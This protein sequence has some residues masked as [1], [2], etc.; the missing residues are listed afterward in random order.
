MEQ[1][2]NNRTKNTRRIVLRTMAW[3]HWTENWSSLSITRNSAYFNLKLFFPNVDQFPIKY[4]TGPHHDEFRWE[5]PDILIS[6]GC[7]VVNQKG[8]LEYEMKNL[9]LSKLN[10]AG[11]ILEEKDRLWCLLFCKA[12]GDISSWVSYPLEGSNYESASRKSRHKETV[13]YWR[14]RFQRGWAWWKKKKKNN[15]IYLKSRPTVEF[16]L[17]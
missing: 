10:D 15:A 2:E 1:R 16:F 7:S 6:P 5:K 11:C 13:W 8:D 14:S 17:L 3:K 4:A 12:F 9:G